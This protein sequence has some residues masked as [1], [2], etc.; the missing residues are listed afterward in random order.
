MEVFGL[1]IGEVITLI[2]SAV[3][4]IITISRAGRKDVATESVEHLLEPLNNE[5]N[6]LREE[7]DDVTKEFTRYKQNTKK[8]RQR[9]S[10]ELT[11]IIKEIENLR[12]REM[13]GE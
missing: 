4:L 10:R 6:K 5:N 8:W 1:T 9:I 11:G 13:D 12:I 7:L 3:A 2:A